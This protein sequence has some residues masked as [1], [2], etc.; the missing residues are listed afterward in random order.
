MSFP[1]PENGFAAASPFPH[2][3]MVVPSAPT[4]HLLEGAPS[5]ILSL[6]TEGISGLGTM[7]PNLTQ[8]KNDAVTAKGLLTA[9]IVAASLPLPASTKSQ[10]K[11]MERIVAT[12]SN[13]LQD[14]SVLGVN[15]VTVKDVKESLKRKARNRKSARKSRAKKKKK[16]DELNTRVEELEKEVKDQAE[17][18][19]T[20][21]ATIAA[22]QEQNSYF[23]S[24][25]RSQSDLAELLSDLQPKLRKR[26]RVAMED[27]KSQAPFPEGQKGTA[28]VCITVSQNGSVGL[29]A[30][31]YCS[32]V[33]KND[34]NPVVKEEDGD[35]PAKKSKPL[36]V[37]QQ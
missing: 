3:P 6:G 23:E 4:S 22:L 19:E 1:P 35:P 34:N 31:A 37:S 36:E 15:Q 2:L 26:R 12:N 9:P 21:K 11:T 28:S 25:L 27:D 17:E 20:A 33:L 10:E 8:M 13:L 7:P 29:E 30:C 32:R 14:D 24:V 18:L 5:P 16:V